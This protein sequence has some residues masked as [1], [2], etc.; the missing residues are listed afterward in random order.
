VLNI[1]R[2]SIE[3]PAFHSPKSFALVMASACFTRTASKIRE[4]FTA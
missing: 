1:G 4:I 3:I 2:L